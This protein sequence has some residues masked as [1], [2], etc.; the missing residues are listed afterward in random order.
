M[1]PG[2]AYWDSSLVLLKHQYACVSPADLGKRQV[3]I[4]QFWDGAW[5]MGH[6]WNSQ[7]L[8]PAFLPV[9]QQSRICP[10]EEKMSTV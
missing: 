4:H 2:M 7:V 5:I 10:Q 3:L 9:S 8:A 6:T 1:T